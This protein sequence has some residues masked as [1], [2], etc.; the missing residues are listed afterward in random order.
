MCLCYFQDYDTLAM[1]LKFKWSLILHFRSAL[2]HSCGLPQSFCKFW[3]G[4]IAKMSRFSNMQIHARK[5]PY[6]KLS[7]EEIPHCFPYCFASLD[8]SLHTL[9]SFKSVKTK[10]TGEKSMKYQSTEREYVSCVY[11]TLSSFLF[12]CYLLFFSRHI[13]IVYNTYCSFHCC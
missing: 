13:I 8:I 5:C 12:Y 10:Y 4:F 7:Q 11:M 3:I 1:T 2:I 9:S 6:Y